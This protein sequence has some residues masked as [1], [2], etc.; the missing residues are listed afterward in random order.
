MLPKKHR[1]KI[2]GGIVS[3]TISLLIV[4]GAAWLYVNRQ[5]VADQVTVWSFQPT[6]AVETIENRIKLTDEGRF[7]FYVTQPVVAGPGEF[8]VDCP[9]QEEDSP[10]LGCYTAG[11]MFIY[12]IKNSQLDGIK[13]VTAAHEMLHAVWERTSDAD[14]ERLS[15]LLLQSYEQ[16]RTEELSSRIAY[17]ERT[18]PGEVIN[19]LHSI[20]PTE[21]KT[22]SP[23][24]EAYYER[25]FE[26]RQ[27]IV[28]LNEQYSAVFNGLVTEVQRL[29]E[30]ITTL[31][32]QIEADRA[33]Y[34]SSVGALDSDISS[35]N[36]RADAGS[37]TSI[38]Q[39][40]IER[41]ALVNRSN[42]LEA[43]SVRL[44]EDIDRYNTLLE[45][46]EAVAAQLESLNRSIDSISDV[47][48]AP[49]L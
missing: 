44:G 17:Y 3:L 22:L 19:E 39:F 7:Y 37:F 26:D 48:R 42:A 41:S 11:K 28:L 46:Y 43:F 4:I 29:S 2:I 49:T 36:R 15:E 13:E 6:M 24:L 9:R 35:F 25:F 23:E 5:Y 33:E 12:D 40:N 31:G 34:N 21:F 38:A 27:L 18:Q 20:L 45:Q 14:K 32:V 10:I 8:N 1:G 30:E 16:G 47:Q